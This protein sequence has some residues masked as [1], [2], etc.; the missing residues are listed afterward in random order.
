MVWGVIS[1]CG[2]TQALTQYAWSR[3][4]RHRDNKLLAWLNENT[5]CSL[6]NMRAGRWWVLLTSTFQHSGIVHLA[7]NM[8]C[9]WSIGSSIVLMLG[10]PAF[11]SVWISSGVVGSI[12]SLAW[13]KRRE[14]IQAEGRGSIWSRR[15]KEEG[16]RW[17]APKFIPGEE[18]PRASVGASS[19]I[20]GLLGALVC[21]A[22][23][24]P[25]GLIFVPIPFPLWQMIVATT[26][27]SLY[28]LDSGVLAGWDHASHLGGLAGGM[29]AYFLSV[30]RFLRRVR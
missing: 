19:A 28:C 21:V 4:R 14:S 9:F 29:S 17:F 13:M 12:A 24:T 15:G 25:I 23:R 3:A 16:R 2:L 18:P 8:V 6:E 26:A 10:V 30:K 27:G 7:L 22:P 5:V 1:A 20:Y 11:V